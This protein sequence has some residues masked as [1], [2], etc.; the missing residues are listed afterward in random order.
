MQIVITGFERDELTLQAA[1]ALKSAPRVIL[2]TGKCGAAQWLSENGIP[3]ETLDALYES[4]RDFESHIAQALEALLRAPDAA[5]CVF[6]DADEVARALLR[7]RPQTGVVGGDVYSALRLRAQGTVLALSAQDATAARISGDSACLIGEIDTRLLAS[8]L[9]LRLG[10]VYGWETKVFWRF[11]GGQ[12]ALLPLEDIDRL[13]SYDHRC[14]CLVN[15]GKERRI[16]RMDQLV[17]AAAEK[18]LEELS[19]ADK[20]P[21]RLAG[22]AREIEAA[23]RLYD[24]ALPEMIEEAA[25][26]LEKL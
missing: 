22:L 14:A 8:D 26:E 17:A 21:S 5:F 11:E 25:R 10:E 18:P 24:E 20:L 9:K 3:F 13:K 23:Q 1:Q 19:D 15:P 6:T 4:A 2:H 12:V 16:C 7:Q